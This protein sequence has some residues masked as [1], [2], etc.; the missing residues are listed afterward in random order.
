MTVI[1]RIPQEIAMI[2]SILTIFIAGIG[3]QVK[4]KIKEPSR[5][6]SA[7]VIFKCLKAVMIIVVFTCNGNMNDYFV[8]FFFVATSM[9]GLIYLR[10]SGYELP[11]DL[12]PEE[13]DNPALILRNK[14]LTDLVFEL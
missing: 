5:L 2:L 12:S 14:I 1:N 7:S 6:I 9:C 3:G 8:A 11:E 13:E 4:E 10:S